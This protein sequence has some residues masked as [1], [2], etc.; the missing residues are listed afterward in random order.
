MIIPANKPRV[1]ATSE[2]VILG[3]ILI[4]ELTTELTN[5]DTV[6]KW[7]YMSMPC[8][9]VCYLFWIILTYRPNTDVFGCA[10]ETI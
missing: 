3:F 1:T 10:K 2:G 4:T 9:I 8:T 5:K 7:K 6:A